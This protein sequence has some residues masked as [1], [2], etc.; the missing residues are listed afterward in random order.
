M[1]PNL[2]SK[3]SNPF[4]ISHFVTKCDLDYFLYDLDTDSTAA[5]SLHYTK[6]NM[7]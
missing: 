1:N 7:E 5:K 2:S 6:Q 3:T 4:E